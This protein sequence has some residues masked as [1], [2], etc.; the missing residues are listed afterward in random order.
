MT[1]VKIVYVPDAD[2]RGPD[3]DRIGTIEDIDP[4]L[5]RVM[6]GEGS[7]VLPDHVDGEEPV[8]NIPPAEPQPTM[9][10]DVAATP[11]DLDGKT[12]PELRQL[13]ADRG[14]DVPAGARKP[15]LMAALG[16]PAGPTEPDATGDAYGA[17]A[18]ETQP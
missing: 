5:A 11:E 3:L 13:A 14:I 7:A 9:P 17:P 1:L 18:Q 16:A 2:R 8:R 4:D 6:I 12:V 15:D 10:A